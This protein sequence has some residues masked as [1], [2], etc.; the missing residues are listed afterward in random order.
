VLCTNTALIKLLVRTAAGGDLP[1]DLT[2]FMFRAF[3]NAGVTSFGTDHILIAVERLTA[4][5]IEAV[6]EVVVAPLAYWSQ[7]WMP[8]SP[9]GRVAH[10]EM[11]EQVI[12]RLSSHQAC[13][14]GCGRD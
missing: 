1:D 9:A 2:A 11:Y 6:D 10:H 14:P 8:M 12:H 3:L 7:I 4:C 13:W 5:F